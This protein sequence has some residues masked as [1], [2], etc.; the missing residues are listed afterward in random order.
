M[1]EAAGTAVSLPETMADFDTLIDLVLDRAYQAALHMTRNRAD[2]EDLVQDAVLRAWRGFEGFEKGTNFKAWFFR[3]LTNCF[4]TNLRKPRVEDDA[5]GYEEVPELYL[6]RQS[7]DAGLDVHRYDPARGALARLDSERIAEA[8]Q[9]LPEEF[10][11]VATLYF[12]EEFRYEEIAAILEVPIGT[13]R[14]RL[15]RARR[16]LQKQLWQL[17]EEYGLPIEPSVDLK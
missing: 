12:A 13:V 14:S 10:R 6:Y 16:L 8:L 1:M 15:H 4:Y 11:V 7:R 5:E 9:S 3:I 17:A 2:A